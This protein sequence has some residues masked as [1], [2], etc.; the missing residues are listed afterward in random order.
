[1]TLKGSQTYGIKGTQSLCLSLLLSKSKGKVRIR[2]E[3]KASIF[4]HRRLSELK[5]TLLIW[6]DWH[7]RDIE[8]QELSMS[9]GLKT[10]LWQESRMKMFDTSV[11]IYCMNLIGSNL[12]CTYLYKRCLK[13]YTTKKPS[14]K[15]KNLSLNNKLD[16]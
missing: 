2:S 14:C 4:R 15:S 11:G 6:V 3:P 9:L 1:M 12:Y 10:L 7:I 5:T 16:K 13:K 8:N